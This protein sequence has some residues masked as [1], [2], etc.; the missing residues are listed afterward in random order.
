M[1]SVVPITTP[2]TAETS[3]PTRAP[4]A[5]ATTISL[6]SVFPI[7]VVHVYS[8]KAGKRSSRLFYRLIFI[9]HIYPPRGRTNRTMETL[10]N[11]FRVIEESHFT[12]WHMEDFSQQDTKT[13]QQVQEL[14]RKIQ[15]FQQ[16]NRLYD[17]LRSPE[18]MQFKEIFITNP[19][20]SSA[21]LNQR[22]GISQLETTDVCQ[23]RGW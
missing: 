6:L 20:A 11:T 14:V 3:S 2:P 18:Y 10:A 8:L 1:R 19:P 21:L 12:N 23:S 7:E 9:S 17:Q 16:Q 4:K 15:F 13:F 5:P 22:R